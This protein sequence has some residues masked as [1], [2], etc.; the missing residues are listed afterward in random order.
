[1]KAN[2][3]PKKHPKFMA[4]QVAASEEDNLFTSRSLNYKSLIVNKLTL[5]LIKSKLVDFE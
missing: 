2:T 1:M 5:I 3:N 4:N